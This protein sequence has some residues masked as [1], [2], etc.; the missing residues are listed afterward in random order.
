MVGWKPLLRQPMHTVSQNVQSHLHLS[1]RPSKS[2]QVPPA[3]WSSTLKPGTPWS[4]L[5][6]AAVSANQ[7]AHSNISRQCPF[8]GQQHPSVTGGSMDAD[9]WSIGDLPRFHLPSVYRYDFWDV[10]TYRWL[11]PIRENAEIEHTRKIGDRASNRLTIGWLEVELQK[12][13]DGTMH[14]DLPLTFA[15]KVE[16]SVPFTDSEGIKGRGD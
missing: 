5:H 9:L 15:L 14:R 10:R 13:H 11:F 16:L 12:E 4:R 7:I 3:F 2:L 6:S 8:H 1:M